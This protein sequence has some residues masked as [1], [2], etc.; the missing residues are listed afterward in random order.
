MNDFIF[1]LNN[2]KAEATKH[3]MSK[4]ISITNKFEVSDDVAVF[5]YGR[6]ETLESWDWF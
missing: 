5:I 3:I 1:F 4:K 6:K 2:V